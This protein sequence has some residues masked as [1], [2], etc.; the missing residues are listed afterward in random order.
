MSHEAA[1]KPFDGFTQPFGAINV[2][3]GTQ[4]LPRPEIPS[5]Y[6][7][8]TRSYEELTFYWQN[9]FANMIE[10]NSGSVGIPI[11]AESA[12]SYILQLTPD[13]GKENEDDNFEPFLVDQQIKSNP[14]LKQYSELVVGSNVIS[15]YEYE[16][17]LKQKLSYTIPRIDMIELVNAEY[18]KYL[19]RIMAVAEN[20]SIGF[21]SAV[22]YFEPKTIVFDYSWNIDRYDQKINGIT[23]TIAGSKSP[24]ISNIEINDSIR[25]TTILSPTQWSAEVPIHQVKEKLLVRAINKK[26][27]KSAYK[28]LNIEISTAEQKYN[29]FFNTFDRFGFLLGLERIPEEDN[30]DYKR[31]LFDVYEHRAGTTY[32]PL[33]NGIIREL[34]ISFDD[35]AI[36]LK[37]SA[38]F[39]QDYPQSTLS[40]SSNVKSFYV[41]SDLFYVKH[42][43]HYLDS[44]DWTIQLKK[45]AAGSMIKIESPVGNE[46][47]NK[48]NWRSTENK[49]WFENDKLIGQPIYV[50]YRYAETLIKKDKK[51]KN[52][53][54]YFT[55]IAINDIN[56]FSVTTGSTVNT[57][58]N[59]DYI[60]KFPETPVIDTVQLDDGGTKIA[61]LPIKW[62]N[63]NIENLSNSDYQDVFLNSHNNL[64]G[65]TINS[66]ADNLSAKFKIQWG[67]A[68]ADKSIWQTEDNLSIGSVSLPTNYDFVYGY[69]HRPNS[70][71]TTFLSVNEAY[72]YNYRSTVDGSN[73][74]YVGV[75]SDKLKSGIGYGT[76]LLVKINSKSTRQLR[77]FDGL[78]ASIVRT[79]MT[80]PENSQGN[81]S[82]LPSNDTG[83]PTT[84]T[85]T[86]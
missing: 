86:D 40:V 74:Y 31:R 52:V 81:P 75:T 58:S 50:S 42:E 82:P 67:T 72:G 53:L 7:S 22:Q 55:D 18:H 30:I 65:T 71:F 78:N 69:W 79:E 13:M 70:G 6:N 63:C 32:S 28:V 64:F 54:D 44:F 9:S 19:W 35:Q 66:Y 51:V 20:G 11:S 38:S 26:G 43:L 60:Q 1:G 41:F 29:Q 83:Y 10:T 5:D 48:G 84:G 33:L 24:F 15:D 77:V 27:V 37:P 73:I 23:T 3:D 57:G 12:A 25:N 17:P 45:T 21:P 2:G 49:L 16:T 46:I 34:D 68:I 36:T 8:T 4:V 56:L 76:D 61:G 39:A 80:I 59:I 14:L 85:V 47:P 62:A